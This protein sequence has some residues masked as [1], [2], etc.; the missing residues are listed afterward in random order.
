[1]K[2]EDLAA[3]RAAKKICGLATFCPKTASVKMSL[4]SGLVV[5][6][7]AIKVNIHA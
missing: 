3:A 1:M 4:M 7:L 2:D 6:A 5:K